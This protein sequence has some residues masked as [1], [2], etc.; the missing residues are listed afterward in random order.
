[1]RNSLMAIAGALMV[2]CSYSCGTAMAD[3]DGTFEYRD[4][5]LP[6]YTKDDAKALDL[7]FIEDSWGIWGH[8]LSQVVPADHS[9]QIYAK[10]GDD[11]IEEQF[12]FSSN[13]LFGY[14]SDYIHN[15]YTFEDSIRFA[16]LP[17]DNDIVCLCA[18]CVKLGN[19]EGNATPAVVSMISRLAAK[20][21]QHIFFTSHYSTTAN[22][23]E[24][25]MPANSGVI[26]SAMEYPLSAKES[27]KE[28]QFVSLLDGWQQKT[29]RIYVWDYINNFDDYYTPYPVFSVMQRRFRNYRDAGVTG[30]FLNGSGNDYSTFGKIR[31]AVLA[32]LLENPD[33]DWEEVL[34]TYTAQH[35]PVAG[36]DI[37]DFMVAQEKMV[38]GNGRALPLYEGV[39]TALKIYLPE[40]EFVDFYNKIVRHKKSASGQEKEDL[41]L[42]TDGMALT[43]LELKR[44][45]GDMEGTAKLK[46]RLGRL[47]ARDI[48]GYNEGY[49]SI[50][51]YLKNY[52]FMETHAREVRGK[53]LLEGK[54]L[55]VVT[56]LDEDYTDI[57]LLTDGLLGIPSNYHDGNLI[58]SASPSFSVGIPRQE[59]M[60]KLKVWLVYNPEF[61]IG[62]PEEVWL[63]AD[64]LRGKIQV[65][66]KPAG[67]S[68]H[69]FVEFDVPP[70]GELVLTMKKDP[71]IKTLAIDEIE[72]F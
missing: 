65:P 15:Q 5:Y 25:E 18:E 44:I 6:P 34:R 17:K 43:M 54:R 1:M 26:I 42:M 13:K 36:K 8:N 7:D 41:E 39:P 38:Q 48:E 28:R 49:W 10:D 20:Y 46:E 72:A 69:T 51:R 50:D 71:E 19:S 31:K 14:I 11:V 40:K 45:G 58:T 3:N 2:V 63:S 35:Y 52:N 64:G 32:E 68:G 22:L 33:T 23:P 55:K 70:A 27:P 67:Q 30:V 9:H 62:L 56:A 12:C 59:G 47:P 37:A 29:D 60:K 66:E 4:I 57:S 53:N 24:A 61:K 21:P 16:I